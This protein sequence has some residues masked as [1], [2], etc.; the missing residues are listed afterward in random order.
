MA[1]P[2]S[3]QISLRA[4]RNELSA[5]NYNGT[6][7][8]TNVS[9][10]SMSTGGNGTINTSNASTN[11][12]NGAAPHNMSE[13]YSYDHDFSSTTYTRVTM[14]YSEDSAYG[15]CNSEETVD[16]YYD[17]DYDDTPYSILGKYK[18]DKNKM[19]PDKFI[20]FL[21]ENLVQKHE[22]PRT[23][24]LELANTLILGKKKVSD[25]EYAVI[26]FKPKIANDLDETK[27]PLHCTDQKRE[28]IYI[29]DQG[30]WE[31]EDDNKSKLRKV[32]HKIANKNINTL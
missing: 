2:A 27:R 3:G 6:S 17:S 16:I 10:N 18:D 21:A 4:I 26:E 5:N 31:K 15:A 8:F 24:S 25:G 9:L 23:I 20:K 30:Q 13:F 32:I 11:R 19:L 14:Y 28:T 7:Q 22:C 12:P 1:V 29:K